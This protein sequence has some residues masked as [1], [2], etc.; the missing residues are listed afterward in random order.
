MNLGILLL[1]MVVAQAQPAPKYKL[2]TTRV[3]R[4]EAVLITEYEYP[5]GTSEEWVIVAPRLPELT[6]QRKVSTIMEPSG[7][8]GKE[9]S[10]LERPVLTARVPVA[11]EALKKSIKIRLTFRA[12]RYSRQ[13]VPLGPGMKAPAVKN[14]TAAERKL[15]LAVT[16][17]FNFAD[18]DFQEWLDR[19]NLRR[20]DKEVEVDFALR[21][22]QTIGKN[23][24]YEARPNLDRHASNVCKIGKS[25]CGGLSVLLV[26]ALRANGVP[27][28]VL[29]GRLAR[30]GDKDRPIQ[31]D[32]LKVDHFGGQHATAEFFAQGVGWVPVD[33]ASG[34]AS[35]NR[36]SAGLMFFG[37]D[38][39]G[40]LTLHIDPELVL[41]SIHYGRQNVLVLQSPIAWAKGTGDFSDMKLK[42]TWKVRQLR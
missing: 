22:F 42:E 34:V 5:H 36:P 37:R 29:V 8:P 35:N 23:A 20:R 3:D 4:I 41:D 32:Q 14:L 18:P 15:A 12:D 17:Q 9:P 13:L 24:S 16:E 28:R 33:M 19:R 7:T 1:T 40:F 38:L 30:P 31:I 11:V 6:Q 39:P 26:A 25:D 21:V 2:Q 10:D 27:A